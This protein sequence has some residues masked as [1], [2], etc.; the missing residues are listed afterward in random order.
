MAAT[1]LAIALPIFVVSMLAESF[2]SRWRGLG[3]YHFPDTVANLGCGLVQQAVNVLGGAI[4]FGAYVAAYSVWHAWEFETGTALTWVVALLAVDLAYYW[5]HRLAHRVN[6]GWAAHV[7]HHQSEEYNLSVALRQ[8]AL[9]GFWSLPFYLPL[10]LLGVPPLIYAAASMA[11]TLYQ[12]WIHTRTIGRLGPL[13]WVLN[14]PS[15]HRV[16][17]GIDPR[18]IDKN[19]AGMLIVWDRL[20]GS[21]E[22]ESGEPVYGTV[23]PLQS[24][25]PVWAQVEHWARLA[26]MSR[27]TRRWRD[28]LQLW[29]RPPEWRPADLGGVVTIPEVSREGQVRYRTRSTLLQQVYVAVGFLLVVFALGA[30]LLG[31]AP[32]GHLE[33]AAAVTLVVA[34][35]GVWGGLLEGRRWA[36]PLEVVRLAALV[37]VV[38]WLA[39]GWEQSASALGLALA[40]AL[41][42]LVALPWLAPRPVSQP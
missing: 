42:S 16:H 32:S 36:R 33:Q 40:V 22:P 7:V 12:Y 29:V 1:M 10:A 41:A 35:T 26:S 18:Y 39:R 14:T 6:L 37:G 38:A 34:A 19:Y 11:N 5:A 24:W 9:Q 30:S 17:H 21:F 13:E 2:W 28:K 4:R 25:N 20:F 27:Q 8:S 15:H 23:K 3:L 31:W